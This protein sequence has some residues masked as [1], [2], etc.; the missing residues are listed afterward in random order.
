MAIAGVFIAWEKRVARRIVKDNWLFM[1]AVLWVFR[2]SATWRDLP[3][4]YH[5]KVHPHAAGAIGGNQAM[6]VTK[7]GAQYKST[8]RG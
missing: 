5:I 2:T 7:K 6:G 3:A 8:P 1:N 4:A